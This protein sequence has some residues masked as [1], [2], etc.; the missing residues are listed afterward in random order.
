LGSSHE[1]TEEKGRKRKQKERVENEDG[2]NETCV[3]GK[4][5]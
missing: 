4:E 1:A 5:I 2:E 3:E